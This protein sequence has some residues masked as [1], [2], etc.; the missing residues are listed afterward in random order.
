L[1]KKNKPQTSKLL[2]IEEFSLQD[3]DHQPKIKGRPLFVFGKMTP[4]LAHSAYPTL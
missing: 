1:K 3:C 4:L 2:S